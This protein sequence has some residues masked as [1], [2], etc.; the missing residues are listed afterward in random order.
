MRLFGNRPLTD[1]EIAVVKTAIREIQAS[2]DIFI[3]NDP[4]HY[5]RTCYDYLEDRIYIGV[6]VFPDIKY[7]SSHP[8]DKMSIRAVLAH[9]Y[10][11]HR[12]NRQ[13]YIEDFLSETKTTSEWQDECR[14]SINAAKITPGL[15]QRDKELLV[16]DAIKR[17][18]EFGQIIET[19]DFMK[20]VLYGYEYDTTK[21]I[22]PQVSTIKYIDKR[23]V[24]CLLEQ[25]WRNADMPKMQR[26]NNSKANGPIR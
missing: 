20:G 15:T 8:R 18:E 23:S 11:G 2:E 24:E 5:S 3:F 19:D 4:N 10:Y 16:D 13:E 14:A 22:V 17:A 21:H 26:K 9:E 12:P 25:Q 7:G 6:N 1:E